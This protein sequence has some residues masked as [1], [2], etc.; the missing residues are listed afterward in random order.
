MWGRR[1]LSRA[2]DREVLST[3]HQERAVQQ[4][5]RLLKLEERL[6]AMPADERPVP[7]TLM[8]RVVIAPY[9][10]AVD[11]GAERE[12]VYLV[13]VAAGHPPRV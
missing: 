9:R 7:L 12:A 2:K 11:A 3:D 6:F 5:A 4:L 13:G 8:R 10:E 1:V